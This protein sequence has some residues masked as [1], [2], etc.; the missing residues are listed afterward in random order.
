M[1]LEKFNSL[2]AGKTA[3]IGI[4]LSEIE[5]HNI[6]ILLGSLQFQRSNGSKI[7][8]FGTEKL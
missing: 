3:K 5:T 6:K 2:A 4:G 7:F 8:F 1:I